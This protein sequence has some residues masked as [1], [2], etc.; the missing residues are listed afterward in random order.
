[1]YYRHPRIGLAF[2]LPDDWRFDSAHLSAD[3]AR[4]VLRLGDTRLLLQV[5]RSQG[6][7]AARLNVMKEHLESVRAGRIAPCH[8]PPFGQSRD[9]VALSYFIGGHQ[10]RWISVGQDGYDYTLSH[11]DD[12]QDVAGAVDRLSASF[13]FPAPAQLARALAHAAATA[14][15][16]AA[17]ERPAAAQDAYPAAEPAQPWHPADAPAAVAALWHRV[18][19]RLRRVARPQH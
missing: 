8:A 12:W 19:E 2:D 15:A 17:F 1:M 18:S 16:G 5:R 10:Q 9:I 6:N 14:P 13:V 4:V 7:A 11:T 3:G